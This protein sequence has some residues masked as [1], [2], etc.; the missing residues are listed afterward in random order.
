[1]TYAGHQKV[2]GV[3]PEVNLIECVTRTPP[4]SAHKATHSGF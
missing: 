1:M 2:A 4:P 3:A